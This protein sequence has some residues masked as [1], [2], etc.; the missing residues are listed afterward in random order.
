MPQG[1]IA[2]KAAA[3]ARP[4]PNALLQLIP[5][6]SIFALA[7][8]SAKLGRRKTKKTKDSQALHGARQQPRAKAAP[9]A[10]LG[11]VCLPTH[12]MDARGTPTVSR[13]GEHLR[14]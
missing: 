4:C 14:A 1:S 10:G 6:T 11:C 12:R 9:C 2:F 3:A 7:D 13:I 5:M 8:K